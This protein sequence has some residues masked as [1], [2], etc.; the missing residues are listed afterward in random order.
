[1]QQIATVA[2]SA[3]ARVRRPTRPRPPLV[4]VDGSNLL[5]RAA[6][7]FP[8]RIATR[9]GRD[10]TGLF[11]FFALLR[12]ALH[13]LNEPAECIVVFDS[14]TGWTGR[15][16]EDP[17]YKQHRESTDFSPITALADI[18][19]GLTELRI[20]WQE[21]SDWEADDVIATYAVRART[22]NVLIMSTDK[23]FYQL[24]DR[25]RITQLNTAR[26]AQRRIITGLEVRERFGIAPEQWCDYRALVGDPSDGIPGVRG[27]GPIRA[28]RL[29]A[30][31]LNVDD[32]LSSGR[33][34]GAHGRRLLDR[35][36]AVRDWR[37]LLTLRTGIFTA[38]TTTGRPTPRLPLAAVTLEKLG[39]W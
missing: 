37:R 10:V 3:A 35:I 6:Y 17:T 13:E 12:K 23:D 38:S 14:E 8:A 31:G 30:G 21:S 34:T 26:S 29:L 1:M 36:D 20:S 33:L 15:R 24:L 9:D 32:L 2:G 22:R 19:R 5:W 7:G 25:P 39:V 16:Q 27:I 18:Q 11:G 4:L 28:R